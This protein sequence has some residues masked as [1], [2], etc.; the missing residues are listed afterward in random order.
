M[1]GGAR[2]RRSTILLES[3]ENDAPKGKRGD[4]G[5]VKVVTARGPHPDTRRP[6]IFRGSWPSSRVLR[7]GGRGNLSQETTFG[8][9]GKRDV[10][11]SIKPEVSEADEKHPWDAS[12]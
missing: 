9:E 3:H 7:G 5:E 11:A 12:G 6:A 4:A 2:R 1:K 10:A 8:E